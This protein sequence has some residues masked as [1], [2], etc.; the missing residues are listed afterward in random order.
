MKQKDE[1]KLK[2]K[3]NC[4]VQ[5]K[6]SQIRKKLLDGFMYTKKHYNTTCVCISRV[7]CLPWGYYL[8]NYT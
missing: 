3:F 5:P 1:M 6:E 8:N 2:L 7:E 4:H